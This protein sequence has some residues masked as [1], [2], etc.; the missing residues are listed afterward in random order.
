MPPL[1]LDL[2]GTT[3]R[4]AGDGVGIELNR[5][6]FITV[7]NGRITGI[8]AGIE[9]PDVKDSLLTEIQILRNRGSGI[10]L[11]ASERIVIERC[12][13]RGNGFDGVSL[14]SEGS[15]V[16]LVAWSRTGAKG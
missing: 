6:A 3:L 7:R 9:G 16:R 14:G 13:I 2:G 12:V 10:S 15:I 5:S 11:S 8:R 1:T 4:G